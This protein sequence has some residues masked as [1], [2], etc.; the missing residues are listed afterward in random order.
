MGNST[1][2]LGSGGLSVL[3]TSAKHVNIILNNYDLTEREIPLFYK[4]DSDK[5]I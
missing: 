4:N 2:H 3:H 5:F 1:F